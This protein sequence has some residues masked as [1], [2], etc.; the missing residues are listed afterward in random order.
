MKQGPAGN[1]DTDRKRLWDGGSKRTFLMEVLQL[2]NILKAAT[3]VAAVGVGL[4]ASRPAS[5]T[6]TTLGFYPS[7]DTQADK[8]F[9]LGEGDNLVGRDPE[10]AVWID[11]TSVSRRHA[12]IVVDSSQARLSLE[13][14]GSKNGTFRRDAA[15]HEPAVLADGDTLTFGSE[16]LTLHMWSAER[17]SE[18]KKITRKRR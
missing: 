2:R 16:E 18:T 1:K 12:R 11:A 3:V 14:L 8:T 4:A 9:R 10:C 17:A 7:T 6:P 5:A 15:V 13:D